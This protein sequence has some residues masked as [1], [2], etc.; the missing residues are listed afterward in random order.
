MMQVYYIKLRIGGYGE[1]VITGERHGAEAFVELELH[2]ENEQAVRKLIDEYNWAEELGLVEVQFVDYQ[3]IDCLDG[4]KCVAD[5]INP[6]TMSIEEIYN[7]PDYEE[8]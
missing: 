2:A 6:C 7:E 3:N 5:T 1:D 4:W 8:D